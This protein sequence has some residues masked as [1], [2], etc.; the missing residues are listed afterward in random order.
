[1]RVVGYLEFVSFSNMAGL[2]VLEEMVMVLVEGI[3]VGWVIDFDGFNIYLFH[4][5]I[6][7]EFVQLLVPKTS[8]VDQK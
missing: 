6:L 7:N 5:C 3:L 4:S 2:E 1:M 8:E